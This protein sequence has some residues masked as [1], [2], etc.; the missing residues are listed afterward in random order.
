MT[1]D[2]PVKIVAVAR[3]LFIYKVDMVEPN[4]S[5][6]LQHYAITICPTDANKPK[7][8]RSHVKLKI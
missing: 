5:M 7:K 3:N 2:K 6:P 1:K 8:E 4:I